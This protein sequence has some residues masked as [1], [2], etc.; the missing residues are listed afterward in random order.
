MLHFPV[1]RKMIIRM[2]L[3][4]AA[5]AYVTSCAPAIPKES[6]R[7]ADPDITFQSLVK[8]PDAYRGK[9][10][11][12]GG[13]IMSTTLREGATW[14]EV[15]QRPLDWRQ[16]PKDTDESYGRFLV[17]F[18]GFQD[19]AIFSPGKNITVLGEVAGKKSM[20]LGNI[21]YPY[22]EL[23]PREQ[24]LWKTEPYGGPAFHIG[25]GVGGVFH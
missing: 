20:L 10:V 9:V 13:Q 14:V 21:E 8:N 3:M 7:Q 17:H 25:I 15:L 11:L 22:P 18:Q 5:V 19:P 24:Y 6:L 16:R 12:L 2:A 4:V 23:I 1:T